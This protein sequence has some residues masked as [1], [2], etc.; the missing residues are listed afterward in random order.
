MKFI[1]V[2]IYMYMY[3]YIYNMYTYIYIYIYIHIY[4]VQPQTHSVT[5][6]SLSC[7]T[8]DGDDDLKT[9]HVPIYILPLLFHTST[10]P[11]RELFVTLV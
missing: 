7:A 11:K 8:V 10:L 9:K 5:R 6:D 4:I 3:I 2:C 1:Y